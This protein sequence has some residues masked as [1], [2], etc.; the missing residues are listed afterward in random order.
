MFNKIT[1]K[2]KKV[3]ENEGKQ[4][5][6]VLVSALIYFDQLENLCFQFCTVT[7]KTDELHYWFA[8]TW[9]GVLLN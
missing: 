6:M 9:G 3:T 7:P 2:F 8:E 1:F 5:H 4:V